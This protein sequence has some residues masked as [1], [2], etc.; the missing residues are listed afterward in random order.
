MKLWRKIIFAQDK[1]LDIRIKIY[2]IS[3][4]IEK[5]LPNH[6]CLKNTFVQNKLIFAPKNLILAEKGHFYSNKNPFADNKIFFP[7]KGKVFFQGSSEW[8]SLLFSPHEFGVLMIES[9]GVL[10]FKLFLEEL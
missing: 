2:R 4:S 7:K 10:Y 1:K 6:F 8:Q 5:L 9:K 3:N